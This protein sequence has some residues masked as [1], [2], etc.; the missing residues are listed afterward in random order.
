MSAS[1]PKLRGRE[2]AQS[3]LYPFYAGFSEDFARS[4]L[5][6][7]ELEAGDWVLDPW[8]GSGTTVSAAASLGVSSRGYDLN[9]VMV[10]VAKARCADAPDRSSI[11][12]LSSEILRLAKK[13]DPGN[14]HDP[15]S[16]WL[17]PE[18]VATLR[19]IEAGVQRL[20]VGRPEY[21]S[22]RTLGVDGLSG[23]A[24]FFYVALFRTLRHVLRPFFCSNPTWIKRPRSGQSR[25]RPGAEGL[26]ELYR[27]QL[28][29]MLDRLPAECSRSA[30]AK[31]HIA[32]ASSENLPLRSGSVSCVLTSPPY[33]TRIDYAVATSPELAVLG[34]ELDSEFDGLRRQLIG[35][36]TVP[37]GNPEPASDLGKSCLKFLDSLLRH[38]SKASSTYYYKNHVQYFLSIRASLV[39]IR[40]VLKPS[41]WCVIVVQ[42]S[43]YKDIHND[44]P[45]ILG[46]MA[47]AHGFRLIE[48]TDF[49]LSRTLAGIN[50]GSKGY[51]RS[52][53]A[54]ETVLSLRSVS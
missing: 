45:V 38:G 26:Y 25:L 54:T 34:F 42:D 28:A 44:L 31:K 51:R 21:A 49:H 22:L 27:F 19:G 10:V 4:A 30:R 39:E 16:A 23:V 46:D 17:Y 52:F 3:S 50:P 11:R 43:Y 9:P 5:S 13:G 18:S 8:N 14:S 2:N 29:T 15:L 20:L 33:C 36:P 37:P 53:S 6:S 7:A 48:K 35:T 12:S 1:N 24:A 47:L 32:V 40:R 41:G